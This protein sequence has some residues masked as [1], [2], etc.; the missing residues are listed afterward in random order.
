MKIANLQ[1]RKFSKLLMLLVKIVLG[2]T[3]WS[4]WQEGKNRIF[5]KEFC[6]KM[7]LK[8]VIEELIIIHAFHCQLK[9]GN[10]MEKEISRNRDLS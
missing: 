4:I 6:D 2:T 3:I 9:P 5:E 10:D 7:K 8:R 1:L